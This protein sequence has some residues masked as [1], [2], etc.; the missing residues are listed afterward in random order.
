MPFGTNIIVVLII[1]VSLNII[2]WLVQFIFGFGIRYTIA[3][4]A[5]S[6]MIY[7]E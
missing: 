4:E 5:L 2:C 6:E 3:R 7:A 1:F